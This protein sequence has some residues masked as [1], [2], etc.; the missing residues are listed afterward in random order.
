MTVAPNGEDA[1]APPRTLS[2]VPLSPPVPRWIVMPR[3]NIPASWRRVQAPC[4]A[5]SPPVAVYVIAPSARPVIEWSSMTKPVSASG[6]AWSLTASVLLPRAG[7]DV[8]VAVDLVERAVERQ[9]VVGH[10]AVQH[11]LVQH[12][13]VAAGQRQRRRERLEVGGVGDEHDVVAGAGVQQC[14]RQRAA[15]VEAVVA[16]AE[17]DV[18]RLRACRR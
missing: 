14:V 9:V 7:V 15:H 12:L 3:P 8:E 4:P 1:I 2:I 17:A 11:G 6:S 10:G 13:Q 16:G 5:R 18:E